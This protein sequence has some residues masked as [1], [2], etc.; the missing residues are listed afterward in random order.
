MDFGCDVLTLR[1]VLTDCHKVLL[2]VH[3]RAG[4]VADNGW[5]DDNK[6]DACKVDA[7][8]RKPVTE[9]PGTSIIG[10]CGPQEK[11]Q[12]T[13]P[14]DLPEMRERFSSIWDSCV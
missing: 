10:S 5:P 6:R 2:C 13:N 8:G 11:E 3:L 4:N 9:F 12:E 14:V 1:E 7:A